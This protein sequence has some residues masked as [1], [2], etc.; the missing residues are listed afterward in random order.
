[1][2]EMK[3]S[4]FE[5]IGE[6]PSEWELCRLKNVASLYTG[7]S[8]KDELK[9]NYEDPINAHPYISSKDIDTDIQTINYENG[10]YVKEDDDSFAVAHSGDTLMCIEGGSAG[11]KKALLNRKVSFVNKLC[12]F[13]PINV[14]AKYL[15]YYLMSPGFEKEFCKY[16]SG[17]IGGVSVSILKDFCFHL[18]EKEEQTRISDFLDKE[19]S[20]IDSIIAKTK[21]SIEE[22]KKLKQSIITEAVTKGLDPNAEMKDSG[23][24]WIG[25][26]SSKA[27]I[28]RLKYYSYMKGRIG[29]Q[30]LKSNDFIDEGPYCIT[31]TDFENGKVNWNKCYHV[32]KERYEMDPYIQVKNGDLLITKDGTIGK[33][34]I[35]DDIPGEAC[36]NSHL[37][38]I[39][40]LKHVF[41]NKYLY[42]VMMSNI[43]IKYYNLIGSGK[44]TM[45][46]L[47]QE[48]TGNFSFPVFDLPTQEQ[49]IRYLD[50]KC[51]KYDAL[52]SK[53]EQVITELEQYKKSLIY[54]YVTGKKEV[55]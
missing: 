27:R 48:N 7:N 21:D 8:I 2:R 22:Y 43:F 12:C 44:T 17:L 23:I 25:S 33:L 39:R 24:E 46:S 36:L 9:E 4:G 10:M 26:Y 41:T 50:K 19:I 35:I 31:G 15:F 20:E 29:W 32:S 55:A 11:K 14:K 40:P 49:I 13:S 51:I 37:L 3:D 53:K 47:S 54:E 38:I 16:I 28:I 5:W 45:A 1:M 18:P 52:I 34:A 42:Y 6:I 30:G